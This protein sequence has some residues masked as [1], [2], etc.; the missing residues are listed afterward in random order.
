MSWDNSSNAAAAVVTLRL[1]LAGL[2]FTAATTVFF[3]SS[4]LTP[5]SN[6]VEYTNDSEPLTS[7]N[8]STL[9]LALDFCPSPSISPLY[10][11]LNCT[12]T[13]VSSWEWYTLNLFS[14]PL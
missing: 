4:T 13:F 6:S 14:I 12:F 9:Y 1:P 2:P 8:T 7:L 3:A 5:G 10:P 11:V